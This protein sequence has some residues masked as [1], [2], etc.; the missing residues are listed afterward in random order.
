MLREDAPRELFVA[1]N[2]VCHKDA[3]DWNVVIWRM[4]AEP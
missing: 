2:S 4:T 3:R 1:L